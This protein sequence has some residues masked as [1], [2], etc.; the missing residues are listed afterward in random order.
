MGAMVKR[1]ERGIPVVG[2]AGFSGSGKTTLI[3]RIV[4]IFKARG[5]RTAVIKHDA[6]RLAFD[7]EGKDTWRFSQAGAD[8]TIAASPGK[9]AYIEQRER[10]LDAL[11][12]MVHDVDLILVE[13]FKNHEL[14]QIGICRAQNGK[15]FAHD[16]GRYLAVVSDVPVKAKCP[17]LDLNDAQGVADLI[18]ET[19]LHA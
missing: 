16:V 5:I 18:A 10:P 3:E 8:I 1:T 4:R 17:C 9:T 19:I 14:P 12:E 7:R 2:F 6:H 13:G 11:L 15:G